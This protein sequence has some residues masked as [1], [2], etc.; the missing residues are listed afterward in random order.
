MERHRELAKL[1]ELENEKGLVKD[2]E[3]A[4]F[5]PIIDQLSNHT[6][7]LLKSYLAAL[8]K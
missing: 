7:D 1:Y 5:Q 3:V 6:E 4:T 2:N 8:P